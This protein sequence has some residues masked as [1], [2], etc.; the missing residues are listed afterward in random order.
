MSHVTYNIYIR[1]AVPPPQKK[2]SNTQPALPK[3]FRVKLNSN[4][5]T[6]ECVIQYILIRH[7]GRVTI[8][9]LSYSGGPGFSTRTGYLD[10][11]FLW[12]KGGE[13]A[14]MPG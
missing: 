1:Y 7:R 11:C 10:S 5:F 2:K 12:Y 8:I 13:K 14:D 9:P 3:T 6:R 4:T